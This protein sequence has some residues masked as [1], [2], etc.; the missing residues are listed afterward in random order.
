M[1]KPTKFLPALVLGMAAAIFAATPS[2]AFPI[3]YIETA[4]MVSGC[5]GSMSATSCPTADTFSD[6]TVTLTMSSDTSNVTETSGPVYHNITTGTVTATVSVNGGPA[7]TFTDEIEVFDAQAPAVGS[8]LYPAAAGFSDL[9]V[10]ADILDTIS[11]AF[12]TYD[13]K[14]LIAP[15]LGTG[16]AASFPEYF[17]TTEGYFN[18]SS[19]AGSVSF[20]APAPLIGRGLPILLAVGGILLGANLLERRRKRHPLAS[21][22]QAT[23]AH[24]TIAVGIAAGVPAPRLFCSFPLQRGRR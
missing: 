11:S 6:A 3:T 7:V 4:T 19:V 12:E 21:W 18:I 8:T 23:P 24:S 14:S 2:F 22:R 15:T 13:L 1:R 16:Y 20:S 17:H 10:G 9:T 5:L